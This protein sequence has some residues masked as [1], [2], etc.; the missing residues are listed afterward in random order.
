[1]G[2]RRIG[3]TNFR[4]HSSIAFACDAPFVFIIGPNGA[5]KSNI[6]EAISLAS[7]GSGMRGALAS[8]LQNMHSD[9]PWS[10]FMELE[11][12]LKVGVGRAAGANRKYARLNGATLP[13]HSDILGYLRVIWLTPEMDG[14]LNDSPSLRR[15]FIDRLTFNFFPQ[16]A[17]LIAEY[18]NCQKQRYAIIK[19]SEMIDEVWISQIEHEMAVRAIKI[20]TQ[21]RN[22]INILNEE[23][24]KFE[25]NF[26]KPFVQLRCV[27]DEGLQNP[28]L[29]SFIKD[30]FKKTRMIDY[31]VKRTTFGVHRAE[32]RVTHRAK[33]LVAKFCSTGEQK[34][35]VIA[36]VLAQIKIIKK[37]FEGKVAVLLDD[38]FSHL[39][40]SR[41]R[42][43]ID[44]LRLT[45][46]QCF[47]TSTTKDVELS[48]A[49]YIELH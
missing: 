35:M 15:K 32:L 3:V 19:N 12:D 8:D 47:I 6:L 39:D 42:Q 44:E 34:A 1:M 18:E 10:V 43:L 46:V 48:D 33:S 26:L 16:H 29:L 23:I 2:I 41:K 31:K 4:S 36:L 45:S 20:A 11:D 5:G 27:I 37:L 40:D 21:R 38:I 13:K 7:P 22:A 25:S 28:D 49:V 30:S 17:N 9:E 24:D 14:I